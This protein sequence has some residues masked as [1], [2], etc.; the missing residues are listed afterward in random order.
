MIEK[1]IKPNKLKN[2]PGPV[3]LI[4][5]DGVGIGPN[6]ESNAIYKANSPFLDSL[7]DHNLYL[8]LIHI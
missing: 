6:V 1:L 7:K 3:V 8:S 2:R 5:L 4:I